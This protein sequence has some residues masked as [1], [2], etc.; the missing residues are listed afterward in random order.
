MKEPWKTDKWFTSPWNFADEVKS[1]WNFADKVKLHDV[2]L[3]DGEQQAGLIFTKDQKIALAE[4][5]AELGVHRIE[6]GMPAVSPQDEAAIKEIVRQD[7][8]PEVFAFA[9]CMKDDVL[10]A[11]DCGVDGVIV[12]IPS[13]DHLIRNGYKWELERAIDMS[14]EATAYAKELDLYTVF[15]PIDASRADIDW[16]LTLIKKVET[17]GHMD[18]LALVDT[19]GGLAP[20]A[21]PYFVKKVREQI[22][23]PLEAH[24]HDDVGMGAANTVI[25]LASGAAVAHTT[26]SA[27][28]ERAGNASYEDVA[29]TL[30]TMYGIDIGLDYSKIYD[31]SQFLQKITGLRVRQNRGIIGEDIAKIESGIIADWYRNAYVDN[32]LE[33]SPYSY[34]LTGHPAWDV[35]IGKNSG[36]P[37]VEI[38]LNKLG[39]KCDDKKIKMEI[40]K[41]V[42]EK[43]FEK[44]GLLTIDEFESIARSALGV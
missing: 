6:A 23:K 40:L 35:V 15:F 27:I 26:I 29:I 38:H 8:G 32:P 31:L 43:A 36:L 18:A 14:I 9:R 39:L 44:Y 3:R 22:K 19:M 10:R 16:F 25:A 13:S 5:L 33:L 34:N 11:A 24:F 2:S 20:N 7:F 17:E 28:G 37:T 12:E 4:K 1:S 42:K 21:I 41:R 30:L